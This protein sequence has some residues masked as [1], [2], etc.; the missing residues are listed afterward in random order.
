MLTRTQSW[1]L[2]YNGNVPG[3]IPVTDAGELRENQFSLMQN[4]DVNFQL[5]YPKL[6]NEVKEKQA[7]CEYPPGIFKTITRFL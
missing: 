7:A 2:L 4:S 6:E 5:E 3:R 1:G